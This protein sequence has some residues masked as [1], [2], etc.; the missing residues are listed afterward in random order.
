M[1]R[2]VDIPAVVQSESAFET[3]AKDKIAIAGK[4]FY[5]AT[6]EFHGSVGYDWLK[7]LVVNGPSRIKTD[8]KQ[9]RDAWL[10]LPE[11]TDIADR[12]HPQVLSVVNRFALVATAVHMAIAAEILPW[13][14]TD[15]DAAIIACMNR[16]VK[17]RGNIDTGGELLREIRQH[18]QIIA[19]TIGDRF[20]FLSIK[21]RRLVPASDT[22]RHKMGTPEQFDG[23]VKE[24]RILVRP[25]AWRRLWAGLDIDAVKERLR[26]ANLLIAG[27]NGECPSLEKF[28]SNGPAARFY[29]LAP[30]FIEPGVTL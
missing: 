16:W 26:R 10:A 3:I 8:L 23:Y 12:A 19:T 2:L 14:V 6:N 28:K 1:V 5:S 21:G 4:H 11:V 22:D 7:H 20:I 18:Q 24:G 15:T 13:T 29:V 30:A 27:P 9:L 17:Q 25:D